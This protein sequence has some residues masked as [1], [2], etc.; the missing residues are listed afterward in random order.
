[1]AKNE[2]SIRVSKPIATT[3]G[4]WD[5]IDLQSPN[6]DTALFKLLVRNKVWTNSLDNKHPVISTVIDRIKRVIA[7]N[8]DI[9]A[10]DIIQGNNS[11]FC[12]SV[13][14]AFDAVQWRHKNVPAKI[15]RWINAASEKDL[16]GTVL[17][18]FSGIGQ[19]MRQETFCYLIK[20]GEFILLEIIDR[21]AIYRLG[22]PDWREKEEALNQETTAHFETFEQHLAKK[23]EALDPFAVTDTEFEASSESYSASLK[24][25]IAAEKDE[26]PNWVFRSQLEFA[27]AYDSEEPVY[28]DELQRKLE[29]AVSEDVTF[30]RKHVQYVL[31]N[32]Q[33]ATADKFDWIGVSQALQSWLVAERTADND[34]SIFDSPTQ[35][36]LN[37]YKSEAILADVIFNEFT[38]RENSE[39]PCLNLTFSEYVGY[40]QVIQKPLNIDLWF[41]LLFLHSYFC[42]F[43]MAENAPIALKERYQIPSEPKPAVPGSGELK[44]AFTGTIDREFFQEIISK[45]R[46]DQ[47]WSLRKMADEVGVSKTDIVRAENCDASLDTCIKIVKGFGVDIPEITIRVP[48]VI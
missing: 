32:V 47:G 44:E 14:E 28:G 19:T 39:T 18:P 37:L 43:A 38:H 36:E 48:Q 45:Y 1:M 3:A 6:V 35:A 34:R 30:L 2:A 41:L 20:R 27:S 42:E 13:L 5:E 25:T 29:K 21:R 26:V 24:A 8:P 16:P 12:Q 9:Y 17:G 46:E 7:V 33:R 15:R 11:E 40:I 31:H 10:L 22:D 23:A 4:L